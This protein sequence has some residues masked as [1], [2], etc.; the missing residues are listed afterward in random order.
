[1]RNRKSDKG[2][3]GMLPDLKVSLPENSANIH[4]P[5]WGEANTYLGVHS[6]RISSP[7]AAFVRAVERGEC[8]SPLSFFIP[9]LFLFYKPHDGN[10]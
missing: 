5:P 8:S 3:M 9:P 7:D 1:M 6:V 10:C 4:R 2:Q